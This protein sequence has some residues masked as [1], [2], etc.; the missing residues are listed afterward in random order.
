MTKPRRLNAVPKEKVWGSPLTEPWYQN[1]AGTKIGEIWFE[2]SAKVPLLLKFLFTSDNLS[3]QVHPDDEYARVHENSRGKTEMW[4]VLRA[5][6]GARVGIGLTE[7]TSRERL[8]EAAL[9]GE[10]EQMM[11]WIPA[12]EGDTF[13]LP[14]GTIHAVGGGLTLCEVQELS[15]VTYRLYDYGRPRELHLDRGIEVSKAGP[16]EGRVRRVGDLL[17]E[18]EYFR[19]ECRTIRG[20]AEFEP[21]R[22]N[23]LCAVLAGSGWMAGEPFRTGETWEIP[24]GL[25][26]FRVDSEDAVLLVTAE[27]SHA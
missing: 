6:P 9:S 15:D 25:K 11:N 2:A 20:A 24:A 13:F 22:A 8:R 16:C 5:E 27:N 19:T 26:P 7:E 14:A 1:S 21:F 10:I 3:I 23:A 12:R 18:C 17:A 4:H